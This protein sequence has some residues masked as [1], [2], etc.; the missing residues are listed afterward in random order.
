MILHIPLFA[1]TTQP[2]DSGF[3]S[4]NSDYNFVSLA[5]SVFGLVATMAGLVY[6]IY[7]VKKTRTAAHAAKVAATAAVERVDSVAA[8]VDFSKLCRYCSEAI[9]LIRARSF[10]SAAQRLYDLRIE[11]ARVVESSAACTFV[12]P[13]Q[14]KSM[15]NAV[16]SVERALGDA[17]ADEVG[18]KCIDK[19]AAV[20][21][22]LSGVEAKAATTTRDL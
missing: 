1:Q 7:L 8:I 16:R 15:R 6:A 5:L 18:A 21:E 14:W 9:I 13:D 12:E 22:R 19:I 2:A 4:G 3:L 10:V 20:H 17:R 11:M